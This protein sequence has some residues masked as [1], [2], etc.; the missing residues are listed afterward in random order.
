MMKI[1][2]IGSQTQQIVS[3]VSLEN[4]ATISKIY[5]GADNYNDLKIKQLPVAY[6]HCE[7]FTD[8]QMPGNSLTV[9]FVTPHNYSLFTNDMMWAMTRGMRHFESIFI[10]IPSTIVGH[11]EKY[12]TSP[13]EYIDGLSYLGNFEGGIIKTGSIIKLKLSKINNGDYARVD[14][15]LRQ[16]IR[17]NINGNLIFLQCKSNDKIFGDF[18]VLGQRRNY[19]KLSADQIKL[20]LKN[21]LGHTIFYGY[22]PDVIVPARIF[23]CSGELDFAG[24]PL[25]GAASSIHEKYFSAFKN[26]QVKFKLNGE[27]FVNVVVSAIG[28]HF[29]ATMSQGQPIFLRQIQKISQITQFLTALN[30]NDQIYDT[31]FP[32]EIV[33][34]G[35]RYLIIPVISGIDQAKIIVNDFGKMLSSIGA[36]FVYVIDIKQ[37]TARMWEN[38]GRYENAATGSAAGPL[39]AYLGKHKIINAGDIVIINQG[40][41]IHHP[42]K[43]IVQVNNGFEDV[44]VSGDVCIV[45]NGLVKLDHYMSS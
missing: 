19:Q 11:R 5:C 23:S 2:T 32:V 21:G 9:F 42:S 8:K 17:L 31:R 16:I 44:L 37:M 15:F 20:Q 4:H 28:N 40:Y 41:N 33:Y 39:R 26:I 35:L 14:I 45:G 1:Q 34:T 3:L 43:L 10:I 18:I 24:R 29:C 30:L 13:L 6:T 38:N 12:L 36:D 7:V 27:R 25:L 22:T